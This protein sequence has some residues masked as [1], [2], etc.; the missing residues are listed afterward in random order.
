M[1]LPTIKCG[2]YAAQLYSLTSENNWGIGDFSDLTNLVK[3]TAS[4]GVS[5]IGLNPL[6]PLY[7]NNPAHCSPYSPMSRCFLN[8]MYIDVTAA[9]NFETCKLAQKR[10]NSKAFKDKIA[11]ARNTDLIDYPAVADVKY[12]VLELLYKDFIK[13]GA[14][15][16]LAEFEAFKQEKGGRLN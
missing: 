8:T 3:N 7:Q 4:Q 1:K 6:H 13:K 9:P 15:A 16:D 11:F 2:V 14:K 12:Q 5:A 10:V